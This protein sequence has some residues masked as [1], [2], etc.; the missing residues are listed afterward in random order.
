MVVITS[1]YI[2]SLAVIDA[3]VAD[4]RKFLDECYKKSLLICSGPQVPRV[5]GVL[6]ANVAS[7]DE[8]RGIMKNDP[9]TIH[10]AAEY[11]FIEFTPI[12]YDQR[13]SCF[14]TPP[15]RPV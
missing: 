1:K 7:V 8:A 14:I 12:K 4:H 5:G 9:F 15:Q 6:I 11:Q 13:F 3:L 10:E 2:K